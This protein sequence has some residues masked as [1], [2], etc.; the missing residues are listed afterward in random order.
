MFAVW[1]KKKKKTRRRRSS[2][3]RIFKRNKRKKD[4]FLAMCMPSV[5]TS[6]LSTSQDAD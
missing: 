3:Q 5:W 2:S 6:P 4:I 1:K